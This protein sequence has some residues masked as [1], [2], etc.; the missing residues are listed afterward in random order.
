MSVADDAPGASARFG[1]STQ[2]AGIDVA[3]LS[4]TQ[5]AVAFAGLPLSSGAPPHVL[6]QR[7]GCE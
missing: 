7:L 2:F 4:P 5:A 3:R 1:T 6:L